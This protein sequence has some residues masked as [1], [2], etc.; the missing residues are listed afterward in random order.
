MPERRKRRSISC[1]I[2]A[3]AG[4]YEPLEPR[5]LLAG[6][7]RPTAVADVPALSMWG[8]T[9][10]FR[11]TYADDRSINP[12]TLDSGDVRLIG[13]VSYTHLTLP[14]ILRV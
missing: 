2:T 12:A 6:D 10:A 13:P 14:T 5:Q 1:A 3:P 11:V 8:S 4:F 9:Y 7:G